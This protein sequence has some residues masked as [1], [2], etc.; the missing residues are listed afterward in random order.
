[1][2]KTFSKVVSGIYEEAF[3]DDGKQKESSTE[4]WKPTF[5]GEAEMS[6]TTWREQSP[7]E[8]KAC[9]KVHEREVFNV[10]HALI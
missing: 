5:Q 8:Y 7:E 2:S 9:F 6:K 3:N 10:I 1:M 4:G